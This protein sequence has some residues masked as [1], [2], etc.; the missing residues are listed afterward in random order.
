MRKFLS[1]LIFVLVVFSLVGCGGNDDDFDLKSEA[2]LYVEQKIEQ[3]LK[4]PSTAD[5]SGWNETEISKT[6]DC[7]FHIEGYVDAENSFGAK[8]RS[9]YS[10][11]VT[12]TGKTYRVENL[13]VE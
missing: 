10:A 11:D 8:L 2:K 12:F 7:I 5:F 9:N 4:S 1:I 13:V 3:V 6:G